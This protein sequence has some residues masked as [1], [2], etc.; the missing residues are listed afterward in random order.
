MLLFFLHNK[1][2]NR[3]FKETRDSAFYFSPFLIQLSAF[4]FRERFYV[5]DVIA[6]FL[7]KI[8]DRFEQHIHAFGFPEL[9]GVDN[10]IGG[11][12]LVVGGVKI[13]YFSVLRRFV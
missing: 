2:R 5:I 3:V 1:K 11:R 4:R 6:C 13:L 9:F 12:R 7:Q 8:F 10:E